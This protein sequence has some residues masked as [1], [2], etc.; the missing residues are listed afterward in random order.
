MAGAQT[1][2]ARIRAK[3]PGAYDDLNDQQLEAAIDQKFPGVYGDIPRSV[4]AASGAMPA[5]ATQPG[6]LPQSGPDNPGRKPSLVT[7]V[8][9]TLEG[10]ARTAEDF[11][12]GGVLRSGAGRTLYGAARGL[13]RML[14]GDAM[15][16]PDAGAFF[17]PKNAAERAGQLV[18]NAAEFAAPGGLIKAGAAKV[19]SAAP[20]AATVAR[21]GLEA[22]SAGTVAAAQGGNPLSAALTAGAGSAVASKVAAAAPGLR[23]A[24]NK[25]VVQALGPTKER[26][27][28]MAERLAP[29]MLK[30]GMRGSRASMLAA[31]SEAAEAA[32]QRVD[33]ALQAHARDR[34]GVQPVIEALEAAKNTFRTTTQMPAMDAVKKG[35]AAKAR[36]LGNGLVELD[37][38]FEPRA[39]KQLDGLQRIVGELGDSATVEQLVSIRRAWDHVVDQ[40]G[41]F[42]HRAG[43]AVGQPLSDQTEA[44]A[45]REAT[46]AIRKVLAEAAPDLAAVNREFAFYK[47]LKDVLT[48][49]MQRTQ[50]HGPGLGRQVAEMAGA[51]AG[52]GSGVG[53]AVLTGKLAGMARAVFTSP[54]YRMVDASLRNALAD[55]I[56]SG[57]VGRIT[58]QLA[59][60][61]AVVGARLPQPELAR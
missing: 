56:E 49:T 54:R 39:I 55:A 57:S 2:A 25:K 24:A 27:K 26:F 59:R 7:R 60:I 19:A 38:V 51:A 45:K 42:A 13:S 4:Q 12:I 8:G 21:A 47:G 48:Q 58:G 11:S 17:D 44:W 30:R 5:G 43:G 18:E 52:S 16:L 9:D 36:D 50:P 29:E 3:Y 20:K 40:A 34:V 46:S 41:G 6:L 15:T 35:V 28:A 32:G 1:L 23:D 33:D 53:T 10:V 37:V 61:G 14:P 31:A 22:V